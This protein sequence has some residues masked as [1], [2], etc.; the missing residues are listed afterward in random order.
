M[1]PRPSSPTVAANVT[2]PAVWIDDCRERAGGRHED[3]EA[4]CVVAD[5][6]PLQHRAG[7]RHAHVGALGKHGVD[8]RADDDVRPRR[9][10]APHAQHVAGGVD[11]H[12][13]EA[14]GDEALADGLGPRRLLERRRR[15]LGQLHLIVEDRRLAALERVDR[16]DDVGAGEQ[17]AG[18]VVV[19]ARRGRLN[20]KRQRESDR[21]GND[22]NEHDQ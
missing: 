2:V 4:A 21:D 9:P 10:P 14:G 6:G 17:A 3:G 13:A 8:V 19:D 11:A 5:A 1:S 16:G 15:D 7:A 22:T 18:G 20:R 12:V